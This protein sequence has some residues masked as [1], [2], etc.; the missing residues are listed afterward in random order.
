ME[1]VSFT[2]LLLCPWYLLDRRLHGPRLV[3]TGDEE[4]KFH[5]CPCWELNT[6][7]PV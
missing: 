5:H 4:K 6:S 1:V 7:R 2:A 3:W